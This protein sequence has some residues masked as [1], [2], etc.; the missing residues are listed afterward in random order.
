LALRSIGIV[1]RGAGRLDQAAECC[2]QATRELRASGGRLGVAYAEQALAK[3]RIRQGRGTEA[4]GVLDEA[5]ATCNEMH[6]GFGQALM[7]RT[8]GELELA[9]GDPQTAARHLTRS[10]EWWQA[11][12][13]PVWQ[14]RTTRDLAAAT[15]QL[16]DGR[17]SEELRAWALAVF[18]QYGCR[19]ATEPFQHPSPQEP[20]HRVL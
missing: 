10:L 20:S 16:G 12:D 14:A 9:A 3:V 11:L 6:D 15:A 4:R 17:R 2:E 18:E 8:M 7:L 19:E 5:L 1:H 13:L